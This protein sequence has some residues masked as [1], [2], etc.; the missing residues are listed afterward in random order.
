MAKGRKT[1]GR[2]RNTPNKVTTEIRNAAR[3]LFD[4]KYFQT[5]KARLD[6]GKLAPAVECKLLAYAF[7][8]PKQTH[9][10]SGIDGRPI[11][12]QNILAS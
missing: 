12:I 4:L 10:H 1:G 11:V 2:K 5:V 6:E 3:A 9:E 8:E 7:G